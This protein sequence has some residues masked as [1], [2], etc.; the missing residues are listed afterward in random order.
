M[1]ENLRN[2][3]KQRDVVSLKEQ[4]LK[5]NEGVDCIDENGNTPLL[6]AA[7][8]GYSEC[9]ELLLEIG[10]SNFKIINVFGK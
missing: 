1:G 4:L 3:V 5:S 8:L 6:Q 2:Y 10:Q 7:F 9:V